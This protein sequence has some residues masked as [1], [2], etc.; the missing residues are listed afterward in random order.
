MGSGPGV[1][2]VWAASRMGSVQEDL[3]DQGRQHVSLSSRSIHYWENMELIGPEPCREVENPFFFLFFSLWKDF[4]MMNCPF[5][6]G[7]QTELGSS[8][9]VLVELQSFMIPPVMVRKRGH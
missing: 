5:F 7:M 1:P 8:C 2:A 9:L 4:K 3:Q 6:K